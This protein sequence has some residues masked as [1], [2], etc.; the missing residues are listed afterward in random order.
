V[1]GIRNGR[2][3]R[4]RLVALGAQVPERVVTN[5]EM[6]QVVDTSDEWIYTR[7][8]IKE[9]RFAAPDE[10]ASDLATLAAEKILDEAG[11]DA[12]EVD[13]LIIP[14]ASPDHIF[15]A[16]ATI[17]ADRIGARRAAAFDILAGCTGFLYGLAQA[18]ALIESGLAG[19]VLVVGA[20][21]L[22]KIT[23][24]T[25]R[26][27]CILFGD[28]AAGALLIAG[29]SEET[30][31]F[32]GFE[33]GADG[34]GGPELIVPAGG[35]RMPSQEGPYEPGQ[36]CI[37][38][39]GR[40]VFKFATR[41]MVDSCSTLLDALEMSIDDIDLLVAHQANQRIIDHAIARL[42]IPA[43][44][45]YNNLERYGNTSSASVPLAMLEAREAGKLSP[46]DMVMMVA[47]GAGLTWGSTVMRF[48]PR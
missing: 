4:A 12:A 24:Q 11:M 8:G 14:T 16:T 25:D 20:E 39:N 6:A 26:R 41:V 31:G 2:P 42:G 32:L 34:S 40:E 1:I 35:S 9:R 38:M 13:A 28:A 5:E 36:S 30:T 21:A 47:F 43:E 22:T 3:R 27:T 19:N 48:E 18:T 37:Q 33:L 15:P 17:V 10:A 46:G 45:V 7:T 44:R 23:D 29:D